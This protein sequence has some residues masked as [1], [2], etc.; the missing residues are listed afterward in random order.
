MGCRALLREIFL[1][2]GSNLCFLRL[3]QSGSLPLAP[4][5]ILY[6]MYIVPRKW[7]VKWKRK[8]N[9]RWK[10]VVYRETWM[11]SPASPAGRGRPL[12]RG[13][14]E[15]GYGSAVCPSHLLPSGHLPALPPSSVKEEWL[16]YAEMGG[17]GRT[18][19]VDLHLRTGA[20]VLRGGWGICERPSPAGWAQPLEG[21]TGNLWV[22]MSHGA[23]VSGERLWPPTKTEVQ[24]ESLTFLIC[25][26]GL[27]GGD[28]VPSAGDFWQSL[29]EG[30]WWPQLG[31][32]YRYPVGRAPESC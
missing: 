28:H 30:V 27:K 19:D 32:C 22:H 18:C 31:K 1:T 11:A 25:K 13:F 21:T 14:P 8:R 9:K 15:Q 10:R 20:Q 7:K 17:P 23:L 4:P 24:G 12:S 3:L 26:M 16:K 5:R 29:C 6:G 2:Q